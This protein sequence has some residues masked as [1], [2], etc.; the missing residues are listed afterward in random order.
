MFESLKFDCISKAGCNERSG[1]KRIS[2]QFFFFF[3]FFFF[4]NVTG[5]LQFLFT[6]SLIYILQTSNKAFNLNGQQT[7]C[8]S[9]LVRK[10]FAPILNFSI[11][12]TDS[13]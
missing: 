2:F 8:R 1:H 7:L 4:G 13:A 9:I 3:F 10:K 11:F 6:D 12:R 5:T